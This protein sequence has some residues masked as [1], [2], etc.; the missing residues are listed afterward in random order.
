MGSD[1]RLTCA[2]STT[3]QCVQAAVSPSSRSRCT[4]YLT[5]AFEHASKRSLKRPPSHSRNIMQVVCA[6]KAGRCSRRSESSKWVEP[7]PE[8]GHIEVGVD[9]EG[10]LV[11]FSTS[12]LISFYFALEWS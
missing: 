10:M 1:A 4:A 8:K 3:R 5:F 9:E 2:Y 6:A 11:Y 7:Q 12:S